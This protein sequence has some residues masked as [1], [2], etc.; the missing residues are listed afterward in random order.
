MN[1]NAEEC[2]MYVLA[3]T[4]EHSRPTASIEDLS[5]HAETIVLGTVTAIEQG[6]YHGLPSSRLRIEPTHLKGAAR[7]A[8]TYLVYPLAKIP[9]AHGLIC[10]RPLGD[11][12]A[13]AVGD[14]VLVFSMYEPFMTDTAMFLSVDVR[15]QL[16]HEPRNAGA[17]FPAALTGNQDLARTMDAVRRRVVEIIRSERRQ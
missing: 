2:R 14:R 17:R 1:G 8:E 10:I 6:F 16:F 9:T 15:R 13:P 4:A 7:R 3:P 12:T 5:T 11:Y